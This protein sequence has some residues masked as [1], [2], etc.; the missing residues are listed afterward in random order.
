M[1]PNDKTS[2][3][4]DNV[5]TKTN[6]KHMKRDTWRV[7]VH[8][9]FLL[10]RVLFASSYSLIT[11]HIAWLKLSACLSHVI[12]AW[13]DRHSTT[14]EPS[15][16]SQQGDGVNWR[17]LFQHR[18]W[19]QGQL[20]HRDSCRVP[21][22][23]FDRAIEQ[24]FLE[25]VDYDDAALEEMCCNTHREHVYHSQRE[26]LTVGF[27]STSVSDRTVRPVVERGR[28]L[29]TEHAQIRTLLDR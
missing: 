15:I 22:R 9:V 10:V 5:K 19:A 21:H 16:P 29:N 12:H 2:D 25:D 13:S 26:G 18:V 11:Q 3:T 17:V 6:T 8:V 14:F 4:N 28:K 27:S 7:N 23:V 24:R 20:L 1:K